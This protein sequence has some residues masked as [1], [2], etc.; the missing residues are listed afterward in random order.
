LEHEKRIQKNNLLI[1][2]MNT[3]KILNVTII[4]S[5]TTWLR[6]WFRANFLYFWTSIEN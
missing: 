5:F 6:E 1:Y 4:V 3:I 2:M